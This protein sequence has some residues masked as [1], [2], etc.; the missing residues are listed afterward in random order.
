[1]ALA[2]WLAVQREFPGGTPVRLGVYE[3]PTGD[4]RTPI[5][6]RK[7]GQRLHGMLKSGDHVIFAH[8]DRGFR[9]TLDFAA[10]IDVWKSKE[11]TVH[12]ADLS[13]DLSTPQGMLVANIMAAVA[14]GQSDLTSGCSRAS[15]TF[16]PRRRLPRCRC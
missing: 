12:F 16:H 9:A 7:G 6:D 11:V 5:L 10:L 15:P 4:R 3:R 8:L 14:Q 2:V 13:V 1:M